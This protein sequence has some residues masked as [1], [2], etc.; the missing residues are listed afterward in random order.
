[1][2]TAYWYIIV[3]LGV[4]MSYISCFF[5]FW[6]MN[7]ELIVNHI[8]H[9][10]PLPSWYSGLAVFLLGM[11]PFIVTVGAER[12]FNNEIKS[13][14]YLKIASILKAFKISFLLIVALL[15]LFSI[16]LYPP[17]HVIPSFFIFFR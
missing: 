17:N 7:S 15:G 1:M 9:E 16:A 11:V 3:A 12:T 13:G 5:G 14:I 4:S 2:K 6:E 10:P 8:A